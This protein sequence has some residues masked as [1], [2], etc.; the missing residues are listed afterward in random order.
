MNPL[1]IILT[2]VHE[3]CIADNNEIYVELLRLI[4]HVKDETDT[5]EYETD[6]D[7][8]AILRDLMEAVKDYEVTLRE[9][10]DEVED[11]DDE[12]DREDDDEDDEDV[13]VEEP[14]STT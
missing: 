2:V 7:G 3:H 11:D 9:D 14:T 1:Q 5:R 13:K 4:Q 8:E 10:E 6:S 12:L